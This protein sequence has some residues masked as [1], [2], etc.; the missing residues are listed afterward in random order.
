M[1]LDVLPRQRPLQAAGCTGE[2]AEA[3]HHSWQLVI[4]Y[5][6]IGLA[7]VEGFEGRELLG[8]ALYDIG[9]A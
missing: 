3:V 1:P 4:E 5:C 9:E 2:E 7:A 8:M 6:Q